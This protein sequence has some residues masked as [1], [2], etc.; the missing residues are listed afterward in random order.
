MR[1]LN[2]CAQG[3]EIYN[4]KKGAFDDVGILDILQI[5]GRAGRPQFDKSGHG[6]FS[7]G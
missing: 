4:A 2:L 1:N 5:F 6:N 3:T 7:T